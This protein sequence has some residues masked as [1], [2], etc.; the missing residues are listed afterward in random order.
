MTSENGQ[1]TIAT[2]ILKFGLLLEYKMENIF[3]EKP[4]IKFVG[5]T[6]PGSSLKTQNYT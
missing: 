1:Q 6:I 5:E 2:H 3:R 4:N